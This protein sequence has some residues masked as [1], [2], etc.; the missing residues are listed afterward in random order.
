MEDSHSS[1]DG[2]VMEEGVQKGRENNQ[3]R[4]AALF[5]NDFKYYLDHHGNSIK[6]TC[7]VLIIKI[8]M[9][10]TGA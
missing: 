3:V 1:E 6:M 2:P 9:I 7:M 5:T 4:A 8:V 10:E